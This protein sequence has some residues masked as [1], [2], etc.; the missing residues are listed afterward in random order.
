MAKRCKDIESGS[1]SKMRGKLVM[2]KGVM[3]ND[4]K[5]PNGNKNL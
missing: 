1:K 3:R 2:Q 5:S 4:E